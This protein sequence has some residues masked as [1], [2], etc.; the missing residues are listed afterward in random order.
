[1]IGGKSKKRRDA[2]MDLALLNGKPRC[3][4]IQRFAGGVLLV[5]PNAKRIECRGLN[6]AEKYAKSRGWVI[7]VTHPTLKAEEV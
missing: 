4:L 7:G 3:T 5:G 1:M 2:E 6:E